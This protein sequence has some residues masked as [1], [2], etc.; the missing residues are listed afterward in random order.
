M[1]LIEREKKMKAL[2]R[3]ETNGEGLKQMREFIFYRLLWFKAG[4]A[5]LLSSRLLPTFVTSPTLNDQ[6]LGNRGI[7][8]ALYFQAT[9]I[10]GKCK[11]VNQFHA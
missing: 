7:Y 2:E 6:E 3:R 10:V 1:E 9:F 8:N 5:N 11:P 4:I